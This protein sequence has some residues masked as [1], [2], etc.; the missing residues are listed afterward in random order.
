M[1]KLLIFVVWDEQKVSGGLRKFTQILVENPCAYK[2]IGRLG[3]QL[4]GI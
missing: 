4:N 2:Q 1:L 3:S